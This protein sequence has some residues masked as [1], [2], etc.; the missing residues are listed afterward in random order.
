LN[1]LGAFRTILLDLPPEEGFRRSSGK[2]ERDRLEQESLSFHQRVREGYRI[3]ADS[4]PERIRVVDASGRPDWVQ[5]Q[6]E[7]HVLNYLTGRD[8]GGAF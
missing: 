3:L 5:K 2:I 8:P 1:K 7:K 6:I 4:C